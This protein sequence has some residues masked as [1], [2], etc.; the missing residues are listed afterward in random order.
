MILDAGVLVAVDRGE[1]AA[2]SFLTAALDVGAVLRTSAP[3]VAQVWRDGSRQ[4]R[5]ARFLDTVETHDFTHLDARLVGG[6]LLRSGTS[7]VV[8]AHVAALALRL[9]DDIITADTH[10]FFFSRP[11]SG[12]GRLVCTTGSRRVSTPRRVVRP[13]PRSELER[14]R[15]PQ[16]ASKPPAG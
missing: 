12:P 14:R 2:Q 13:T 9:Q 11:I 8:D 16:H 7:D 10:D 15:A 3:V 6:M 4:A 5:L 1:Q